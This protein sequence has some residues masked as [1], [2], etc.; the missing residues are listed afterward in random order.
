[1]LLLISY[2]MVKI[3]TPNGTYT[4]AD[5]GN[6]FRGS[7]RRTHIGTLVGIHD[8]RESVEGDFD[9]G[10]DEVILNR[11][12]FGMQELPE[13][14]GHLPSFTSYVIQSDEEFRVL[15]ETQGIQY[16]G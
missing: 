3:K 13:G 1:M 14:H 16:K 5:R 9:H 12:P 10:N 8:H 11:K 6:V 7:G 2:N 4:I 15:G